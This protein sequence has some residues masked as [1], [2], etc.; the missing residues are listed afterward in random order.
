MS[1]APELV[2]RAPKALARRARRAATGPRQRLAASH[3]GWARAAVRGGDRVRSVR[4]RL[5]PQRP[6]R[7]LERVVYELA[8]ALPSARFVQVGAHDGTQLDPLRQ[9]I[10][11]S[12]WSGVMVEP[13]PYVFAR[14]ER[15]YGAHPRLTLENVAIA[16]ADGTREFH[17]LRQAA[18]AEEVWPWY[19]ALGSFRRDVVL[20]HGELVADIED[21]LVTVELPCVTFSTLCAR[22]GIDRL[23]LVQIDTEGYDAEV[24]RLIDLPRL[25]PAVVIYEHLHLDPTDREMSRA[26][27]EG[28][29][30]RQVSDGMD[31]ICVD[32][33]A[34][35]FPG[36]RR[37][38]AEAGTA[39]AGFPQ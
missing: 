37:A 25:R 27:M 20:S 13:V 10:L 19:D 8:Q 1:S 39:L 6:E 14:L 22:N 16:E 17:H 30:Y 23:D 26:L 29:G 32:D 18:E 11:G 31:T 21:R 7:P 36:V 35:S 3:P 2:R 28:H 4:A 34:L 24:L 15:R 33:R 5:R 38:F 12:R 9:A